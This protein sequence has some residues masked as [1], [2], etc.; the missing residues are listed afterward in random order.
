MKWNKG[1]VIIL[2]SHSILFFFF[3]VVSRSG[4]QGE[5]LGFISC[6]DDIHGFL[7]WTTTSSDR[8][9]AL[10]PPDSGFRN[11]SIHTTRPYRESCL[12]NLICHHIHPQFLSRSFDSDSILSLWSSYYSEDLHLDCRFF[13]EF[14]GWCPTFSSV[15]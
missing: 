6:S 1:P 14:A 3:P 8:S 15:Q 13:S 12:F 2:T 7:P 10:H 9:A 11:S 4:H 5:F